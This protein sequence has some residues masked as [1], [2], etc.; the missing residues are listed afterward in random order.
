MCFSFQELEEIRMSG[1]KNFR[2][3][4]VEESNL[5]SWQG[6]IVPVSGRSCLT[7][8]TFVTFI[9][10][11]SFTRFS[12]QPS[13]WQR[14]VQDRNHFSYRVSFQA[15]Q[16]HI[17]DQDL[18]PEHWREGPGVLACDQRRELEACHQNWPR[19]VV[20]VIQS[21][22]LNQIDA[23]WSLYVFSPII[24]CLCVCREQKLAWTC[25]I[26]VLIQVVVPK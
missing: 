25:S 16:D 3:I 21:G 6:L 1:M 24:L 2:N 11:T 19:W 18:S 10:L 14:C 9:L 20:E 26:K 5:L 23:T 4:Q 12:G 22:S 7:A 15:S 8:L 17:Q 13:L